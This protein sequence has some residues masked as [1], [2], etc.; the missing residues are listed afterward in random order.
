MTVKNTSSKTGANIAELFDDVVNEVTDRFQGPPSSRPPPLTKPAGAPRLA[1]CQPSSANVGLALGA[2]D[3]PGDEPPQPLIKMGT[4]Q[5]KG[6][7][8]GCC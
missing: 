7:F 6:L 1:C 8:D 5:E 4:G 2:E 3:G